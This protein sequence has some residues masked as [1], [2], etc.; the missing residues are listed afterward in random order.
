VAACPDDEALAGF[1]AHALADD[2]R[3]AVE[4]HVHACARCRESVGLVA[5][6]D[7]GPRQLGRYR[8][9]RELGRGGMGV[10]WQAWDPALERAVAIKLLRP[11]AI[12]DQARA[13]LLREARAL[14]Q[15]QH[16]NVVAVHD[17]GEHGGDVYLATELVD[18]EDLERWQRGR[19]AGELLAAYAQAARGLAAAHALGLVHRDVKPSNIFVGR[20]GRVR[21]GDFGLATRGPA[22]SDALPDDADGRLTDAGAVVGTPAYMAPEQRRG[23]AVDA[24]A[25]QYS[26]CVALVEALRGARPAPGTSAAALAAPPRRAP[27]AT[28]TVVARRGAHAAPA[29]RVGAVGD[30]AIGP[31]PADPEVAV[32]D[33]ALA[34]TPADRVGAVGDGAIAPTP[35]GR[36]GAV[37][38]GAIGPSPADAEAAVGDAAS[39]ASGDAPTARAT[40]AELAE[41]AAASASSARGGRPASRARR[42]DRAPGPAAVPWPAIARA[43]STDPADRHPTLAPLIEALEAHAPPRRRGAIVAG[44]A[45]ALAGVAALAL[46][47]GDPAAACAA[48]RP[49]AGAW[50]PATG[51][52]VEAAFAAR[53]LPYAADAARATVAA[54]DAAALDLT[55]ADRAACVDAA[56]RREPAERAARRAACLG[57][58]RDQIV[59]L[60]AGLVG[61]PDARMIRSAP[62]GARA[63]PDPA[64]CTTALGLADEAVVPD[65]AAALRVAPVT[66]GV[67]AARTLR[68]LGKLK[69]ARGQADRSVAAARVA[70]YLPVLAEAQQELGTILHHQDDPAAEQALSD[71]L[72]TA[73]EA[74]ADLR[75]ARISALLV[76]V[77]GARGD[78]AAAERQARLARPAALRA[79]DQRALD[80]VI[81]RGL[82]RA[83]HEAQRYADAYAHYVRAEQIHAALGEADDVDFD[84]RAQVYAL[85]SSDRLAEADRITDQLL[86]S[87]R[88][89]L[90]ARHPTTI[91]DLGISAAL[92]YKAGRYADA[93]RRFA[94]ALALEEEGDGPDAETVAVTRAK[95]ATTYLA[96][97]RV[98]EAEPLLRAAIRVLAAGGDPGELRDQRMNLGLVLMALGR[99]ADAEA[100]IAPVIAAARTAPDE[101]FLAG[102]LQTHAE[103]LVRD[104]RAAAALPLARDALARYT[105]DFGAASR[106]AGEAGT[107]LGNALVALHRPRDAEAAYRA[108]LA[109]YE[110]AIG[111]AAP[112]LGEPLTGLAELVL[113]RD[114]AAAR[115]LAERAV[116]VLAS[117]DP[118]ELARGQL[119][120]A[121][122]R[123]AL[124]D[125]AARAVAVAAR[126]ALTAAGPRAAARLAE[127]DAWLAAHP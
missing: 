13:R 35:A 123:A 46:R 52:A 125:P 27:D 70:G 98:A 84:R 44:A 20:D 38:D 72:A 11:D 5:A 101:E 92:A 64:I 3:A 19:P 23:G 127:V 121:R 29:D 10:V 71:A 81:E 120:L 26:L 9:D 77:I 76:E 93:A 124:G 90:G 48:R 34:P 117:A 119:V 7:A 22:A 25:D 103:L 115:G 111:P 51:A 91:T 60:V 58:V 106:H 63:L 42:A 16:P 89:L 96:L 109:A 41:I 59:G 45:L 69:A 61:A 83:H 39:R 126:A 85:G 47:G 57:R 2:A 14:A 100:E 110:H 116:A 4:A 112:S 113:A 73:A 66:A 79:G 88:A 30:G 122:A 56:H 37:G 17:V 49:L 32:G 97:G 104:H 95:L 105:R 102:A 94:T 82:G 24:R 118:D 74:H 1:L 8:L 99:Y 107:T 31:T 6:A 43:L 80:A 62:A 28:R 114:P 87:D 68:H 21:V 108:A 67:T 36:V 33:G 53:H 18:G 50:E 75:A 40:P 78:V 55:R 15:L 65:L 54:L 12:D 86:A